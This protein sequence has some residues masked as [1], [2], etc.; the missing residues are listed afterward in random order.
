MFINYSNLFNFSKADLSNLLM[1]KFEIIS[2]L[3]NF[4]W[5]SFNLYFFNQREEE[6]WFL[7]RQ[8]AL[9]NISISNL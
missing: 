6:N 5:V 4:C 7:N 3:Y 8:D 1:I 9:Q 2:R